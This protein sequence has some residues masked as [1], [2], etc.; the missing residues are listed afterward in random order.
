VLFRSVVCP[1]NV[2]SAE[3]FLIPAVARI[4]EF[5]ATAVGA[6]IHAVDF[7]ARMLELRAWAAAACVDRA[8]LE[9][10]LR[11]TIQFADSSNYMGAV[12]RFIRAGILWVALTDKMVAV[13][14]PALAAE[15]SDEMR[16]AASAHAFVLLDELEMLTHSDHHIAQG[17]QSLDIFAEFCERDLKRYRTI[18]NKDYGG[19]VA[20]LP[21]VKA[22]QLIHF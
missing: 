21:S 13:F 10:I 20:I 1:A 11:L 16:T 17:L 15:A 18:M 9:V 7:L 6:Q 19:P 3:L 2:V 4:S 8:L 5:A 12:F 22:I 14:V